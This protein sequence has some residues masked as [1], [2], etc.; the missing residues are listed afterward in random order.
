[1]TVAKDIVVI[2]ASRLGTPMYDHEKVTLNA[3]AGAIAK[4]KR[5]I[6][7]E[8]RCSSGRRQQRSTT[9]GRIRG[10]VALG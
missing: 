6:A 8:L 7:P 2:Y 9:I 3:V 4:L 1:M 5:G 10:I